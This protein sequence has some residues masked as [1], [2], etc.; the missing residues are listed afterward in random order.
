SYNSVLDGKRALLLMDNARDAAQIELLVPPDGCALL[1]TSRWHFYVSGLVAKEL[2]TLPTEDAHKLLRKIA[3]RIGEHDAE[4]ARLCG[5]LPFALQLA[6]S[7]L[8]ERRDL[9]P[10]DYTRRLA[11][12]RERLKLLGA[13]EA[14]LSLS[15]ELLPSERQKQWRALGVFPGTFDLEAAAAVLELERDAAQDALG[16]LVNY[17]LLEF[18]ETEARY[19]LHDLA[20]LSA[21]QRPSDEE[22]HAAELRHSMHY[23]MLLSNADDLYLQGG[24]AVM[25]GLALFDV[26]RTNIQSGQAWAAQHTDDEMATR[27]CSAYP[28]SGVYILNLRLHPRERISWL[29]QALLA[30]RRTGDHHSEGNALGN[31]GNVYREIG[32][33]RRAIEFYEQSLKLHREIGDRRG[34]GSDLSNLGLSYS[35]LGEVRRAI[36]FYKQALEIARETGDRRSEANV[37][38]NLGI[39]YTVTGEARQAIEFYEQQLAIVREIG[40]RRGES[41]ALGNLGVTYRNIGEV[42]RAIEF[43]K[44]ALEIDREIGYRRGEGGDLG[45]LGAAHADLGEIHQ[46]I[47]FYEQHLNIAREVGDLRGRARHFSI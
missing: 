40:D 21:R 15:Y 41:N 4:I 23:L 42:R 32:E 12:E 10:A 17:S 5:Y 3:P 29:K 9:S 6:A 46:A 28:E 14:S 35:D 16:E 36:E 37:L 30:T 34:E 11:D 44:Q 18:D 43:Y 22:R 8:V 13:V 20:R 45:N 33:A 2:D 38:G 27:L 7:A 47:E 19:S 39:A 31:T 25:R 1:V 26:E 24:D